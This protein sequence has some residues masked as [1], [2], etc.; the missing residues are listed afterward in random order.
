MESQF[1]HIIGTYDFLMHIINGIN[2][3]YNG[4]RTHLDYQLGSA[5]YPPTLEMLQSQAII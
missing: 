2:E 3:D 5:I 1:Q 4:L